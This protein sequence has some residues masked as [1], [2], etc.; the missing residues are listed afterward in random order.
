[1]SD[2]E[3]RIGLL[4]CLSFFLCLPALVIVLWPWTR[5]FPSP[6]FLPLSFSQINPW[7]L[8]FCF[9]LF[10]TYLHM[11]PALVISYLY[12]SKENLYDELLWYVDPWYKML[13]V[14]ERFRNRSELYDLVCRC[15][16]FIAVERNI[17]QQGQQSIC[18]L[19]RLRGWISTKRVHCLSSSHN[20]R[21]HC[22]TLATNG[23]IIGRLL[24][25]QHDSAAARRSC[26]MK[27]EKLLD[28]SHSFS[29]HKQHRMSVVTA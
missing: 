13:Y 28:I 24:F 20:S 14:I 9:N 22:G 3:L 26:A 29:K 27:A 6:K 23:Q 10:R 18:L 12:F 2:D 1:M 19:C 16:F 15:A 8:Y 21:I 5:G 25:Y 11:K 17:D 4:V 7:S